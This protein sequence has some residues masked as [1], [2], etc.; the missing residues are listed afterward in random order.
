MRLTHLLSG[1]NYVHGSQLHL[2]WITFISRS[3]GTQF[4]SVNSADKVRI[5]PTGVVRPGHHRTDTHVFVAVAHAVGVEHAHIVRL[6][7]LAHVST[8]G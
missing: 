7:V 4:T 5:W 3:L 8:V 2:S 1:F 6:V